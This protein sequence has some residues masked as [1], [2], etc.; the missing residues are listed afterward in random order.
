MIFRMPFYCKDFSCIAGKCRDSCCIG[1][2]ID[3]DGKT[4]AY[5]DSVKGDFGKRLQENIT[6]GEVRSFCLQN[7]RC[8]FLNEKNL[9]D[10]ILTL[11]ED[12]LCQICADHPRYFVWFQGL[13]EGGVGLCCEEAAR[14]VLADE[15]LLSFWERE[16]TDEEAEEYDGAFFEILYRAREEIFSILSDKD[17]PFGHRM[18]AVL[19]LAKDLQAQ[20]GTENEAEN[21]A[22]LSEILTSFLDIEEMDPSWKP[23]LLALCEMLPFSASQKE[24]FLGAVTLWEQYAEN[25]AVYFIYRHFLLA[26]FD[27]EVLPRVKLAAVSLLVI[28][29]LWLKDFLEKGSLSETDAAWI[30]KNYSKEIEYNE[31]NL[32]KLFY[33]FYE[34]GAVGTENLKRFFR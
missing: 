34:N 8:P 16:I 29:A 14:L 9:C 32:E 7:E 24:A 25:L 2:E 5:Y 30:A 13:K 15:H 10:I 20:I 19:D 22:A 27:G 23:S 21:H 3:V 18:I 26:V 28:F 17:L 11:G 12:K 31:E 4:A 33:L 6:R 1:W